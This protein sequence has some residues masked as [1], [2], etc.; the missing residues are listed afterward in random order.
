M[1]VNYKDL[2]SGYSIRCINYVDELYVSGLSVNSIYA[3]RVYRRNML[4][5]KHRRISSKAIKTYAKLRKYKRIF[6][7]RI[8]A[9]VFINMTSNNTHI[10]ITYVGDDIREH[11][12]MYTTGNIAGIKG[13]KRGNPVAAQI[14]VIRALSIRKKVAKRVRY[15]ILYLSG[16]GRGR[17]G[18]IKLLVA[19]RM[20]IVIQR[21]VTARP[22]NGTRKRSRRRV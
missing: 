20:R 6:I 9:K 10:T 7:I 5:R 12:I 19:S 13:S 3:A 17:A 16:A 15:L 22:F 2:F 4:R 21:E 8:T 18:V 1:I 14:V 11:S